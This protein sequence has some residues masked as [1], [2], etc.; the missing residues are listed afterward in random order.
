MSKIYALQEKEMLECFYV[1]VAFTKGSI[2]LYPK[3]KATRKFHFENWDK[4]VLIVDR[5]FAFYEMLN[6]KLVSFITLIFSL[7]LSY[8]WLNY[9]RLIIYNLAY[10]VF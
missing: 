10:N 7:F 1:T 8:C 3:S 5:V 6:T 4:N 2:Y 9:L